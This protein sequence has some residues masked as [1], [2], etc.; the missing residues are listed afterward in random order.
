MEI[1]VVQPG[2]TLDSI[3][4]EFGVPLSILIIV[5]NLDPENNITVGQSLLILY[6][7]QVYTVQSGDSLNSIARSYNT[8]VEDVLRNNPQLL[9]KNE[10]YEGQTLVISYDVDKIRTIAVNGYIYPFV[11]RETLIRTLPYLTYLTLF[12]YGLTADGLLVD[13]GITD[14]GIDEDELIGLARDYGVAPIMHLSTL[15]ENGGFSSELA[16]L[17]LKDESAQDLL[18]ENIVTRMDEKGYYGLDIDFEYLD[19]TDKIP[20]VNFLRKTQNT[21]EKN[22]YILITALAPKSSSDQIGALYESHDYNGIGAVSDKV[23]LMTYEWGYTYG[24]PMAVSPLNEMEKVVKYG[25]S[26]IEPG[27]IFLGMPNY[28]YD[29]KLPYERGKSKAKKISNEEAL[30]LAIKNGSVIMFDEVAQTPY[31]YY[32]TGGDGHVV[33]FDDVRSIK[34]KLSL[35]YEYGLYGVSYWNLMQWFGQ[36]WLLLNAMYDIERLI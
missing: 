26:E 25:V 15:T 19:P 1:Y 17:I 13:R 4:R 31:Y 9:G 5:N 11:E 8:S 20:Y 32:T 7:E 22:G 3:A 21:L 10:I 30:S 14:F 23:L 29:W 16:K 18:I 35:I 27:K 24:P 36:N 28:S 2:D 33:W 34:E 6:P 12:T